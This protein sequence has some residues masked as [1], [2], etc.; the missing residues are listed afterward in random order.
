MKWWPSPRA[1]LSLPG[2]LRE[3]AIPT[4]YGGYQEL[5]DDPN[6]DAI[7]NPLPNDLHVPL[8]IACI[9]AGKRLV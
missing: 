5:L 8:G 3:F 4:A 9:E 1:A 6:V 7:Y 2:L